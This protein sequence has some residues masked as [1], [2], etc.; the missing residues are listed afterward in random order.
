M[1]ALTPAL[2][3]VGVLL[4][5]AFHEAEAATDLVS[6][7]DEH[8]SGGTQNSAV[9]LGASRSAVDAA[10]AE[11]DA[12]GQQQSEEAERSLDEATAD[13]QM[14]STQAIEM[15]WSRA[16]EKGTSS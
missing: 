5:V 9:D 2:L 11:K 1:R 4:V 16:K 12:S 7:M 13:D 3:V 15:M 14:P 6:A 10:Q 8:L